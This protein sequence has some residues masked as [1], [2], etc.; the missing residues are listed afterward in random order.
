MPDSA[1][2]INDSTEQKLPPKP[3]LTGGFGG[4]L[5]LCEDYSV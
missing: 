3:A 4:I 1:K 5:Q 2:D